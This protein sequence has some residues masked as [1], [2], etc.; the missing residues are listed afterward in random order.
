MQFTVVGAV[1]E[2]L[3]LEPE[4]K[5]PGHH[6]LS[7]RSPG[8]TRRLTGRRHSY[9]GSGFR[10]VP[11]TPS[12][13]HGALCWVRCPPP[14]LRCLLSAPLGVALYSL[15]GDFPLPPSL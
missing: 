14:P 1:E 9:S 10:S 7:S 15:P 3:S 12:A 8:G 5:E 11:L 2:G 6:S 4:R 13:F